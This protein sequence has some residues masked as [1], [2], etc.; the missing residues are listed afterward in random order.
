[1]L[2][3]SKTLIAFLLMSCLLITAVP[4]F[5]ADTEPTDDTAAEEVAAEEEIKGFAYLSVD[6]DGLTEVPFTGNAVEN[7]VIEDGV[8]KGTSTGGD[9]HMP[10]TP[11]VNFA[12]DIVITIIRIAASPKALFP[13]F[14]TT[15]T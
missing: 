14:F 15:D 9:P 4:A 3:L 6:F 13:V 2:K 5:A 10:Y 8:F 7:L 12:A 11:G 1:M